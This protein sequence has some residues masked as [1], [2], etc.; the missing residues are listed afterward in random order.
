LTCSR[1]AAA[2]GTAL[3]ANDRVC[4]F[5][6]AARVFDAR[7]INCGTMRALFDRLL[8]KHETD[9]RNAGMLAHAGCFVTLA[10]NGS[11]NMIPIADV[12]DEVG[13]I[14]ALTLTIAEI[15]ITALEAA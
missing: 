14:R 13:R 9:G 5:A 7:N 15:L 6:N 10:W 1:C 11:T 4:A 3:A 8:V 12:R 2:G